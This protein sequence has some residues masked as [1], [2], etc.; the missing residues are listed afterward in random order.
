MW[1]VSC[2]CSAG[3]EVV[4]EGVEGA[5]ED[6]Q[7]PR[8]PPPVGGPSPRTATEAQVVRAASSRSQPRRG[9]LG[10]GGHAIVSHSPARSRRPVGT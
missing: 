9:R 5:G 7:A 1:E 3:S 8:A 10:R 6:G 4:L 2:L